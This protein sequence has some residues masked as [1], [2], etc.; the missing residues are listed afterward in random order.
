VNRRR[1]ISTVVLGGVAG[2]AGCSGS[3]ND[4]ESNSGNDDI[5]GGSGG[6]TG[7]GCP[8]VPLSYTRVSSDESPSFSVEFPESASTSEA[9]R[10]VENENSLSADFTAVMEGAAP[11]NINVNVRAYD[12]DTIDAA[13]E[14]SSTYSADSEILEDAS[15]EYDTAVADARVY[16]DRVSDG[17]FVLFVPS[18]GRVFR[19][20]IAAL[21]APNMAVCPEPAAAAIEHAVETFDP[22]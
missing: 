18:G 13:L 16:N 12:V 14:A 7:G 5:G 20:Q 3:S 22:A 6:G 21:N 11:Y 2:L 15:D 4:D 10:Q 9:D 17:R 19:A 8:S 1:F